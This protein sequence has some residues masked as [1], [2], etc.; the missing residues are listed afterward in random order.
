[1]E[2]RKL[3][4][5]E[6]EIAVEFVAAAY[7]ESGLL[8]PATSRD[9]IRARMTRPSR[10]V[11]VAGD[12]VSAAACLVIR[13][14]C[15]RVTCLASKSTAAVVSVFGA[16][17]GELLS[18]GIVSMKAKVHP[19]YTKFYERVV[20]AEV[21]KNT[22]PVESVGGAAGVSIRLQVDPERLLK[23]HSWQRSSVR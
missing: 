22:R 23:M 13:H 9:V 8:D 3:T 14:K 18:L 19:K 5:D 21:S 10:M 16:I 2:V 17:G 1:M 15:A 4:R 11:F 12:P 20:G 7:V 6:I